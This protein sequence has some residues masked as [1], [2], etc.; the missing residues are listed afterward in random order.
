MADPV[1]IGFFQLHVRS[2]GKYRWVVAEVDGLAA[3]FR[4]W[5]VFI[6]AEILIGHLLKES[7]TDHNEHHTL[8]GAE[9]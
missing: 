2:V 4:V 3:D 9:I 7:K 8:I 1:V 5:L 6:G